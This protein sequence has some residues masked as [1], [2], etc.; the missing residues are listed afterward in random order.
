MRLEVI[1]GRAACAA[2]VL[3]VATLQVHR[4]DDPDTWWHLAAG[5]QIA[6]TGVVPATDSF[7]YTAAGEPWTNRQWLFEVGLYESWRALG[8]AGPAL[9]AGVLFVGAALCLLGAAA[10]SAPPW[11]AAL[12]VGLA[13]LAMAERFT[14]RPEAATFLFVGIYGLAL[15]R[16]VTWPRVALLAGLQVVWANV[17]ALS[18]LAFLPVGAAIVAAFAGR[19][20]DR[21]PLLALAAAVT[22]AEVATPFGI[23]GALLP[24]FLLSLISGADRIS[25]AIVEHRPPLASL[26]VMSP[27]VLWAW[28]LLLLVGAVAAGPAIR[29]RAVQPLLTAL[30]FVALGFLARRNVA[31]VG[32]GVVPLAAVVLGPGLRAWSDRTHLGLSVLVTLA[33]TVGVAAVV[34]GEFYERA[35]LTRTFGLGA[36]ELLFPKAA[37]DHLARVAPDARLFNDDMLGGFVTW[38]TKGAMRVFFDGRL[39]VY[40][41]AIYDAYQDV[42]DDP[43]RFETLARTWDLDAVL[44]NHAAAG[45]LELAAHVARLD[46]WTV[47]YLGAGGIV[48]RRAAAVVGEPE[49]LRDAVVAARVEGI[50]DALEAAI[51]PLRDDREQATAWYQ[52]GR[53]IHFLYGP[54]GYRLAQRD[55]AEALRRRPGFTAARVGLAATAAAK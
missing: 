28:G 31:L 8:D 6:T 43:R 24:V 11:A 19:R 30:G 55:F 35:R 3:F 21:G 4:L 12:G 5:R 15:A 1:A 26:D 44:L 23:R 33:A 16:E 29:R 42:L 9:M 7:S 13:G 51:A 39:Q 41:A 14:V 17:H 54:P 48:L 34:H 32:F 37:V 36:S 22:L 2:V 40:P 47:S 38:E 52:R 45:R 46:G 49:G 25:Y 27:P 50:A 20:R 53:A 10:R 18:V